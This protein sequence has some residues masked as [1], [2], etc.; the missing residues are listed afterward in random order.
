MQIP[1]PHPKKGLPRSDEA[2]AAVLASFIAFPDETA[3]LC[4]QRKIGSGHFQH[5]FYVKAFN[6]CMSLWERGKSV[7]FVNVATEYGTEE[8]ER[9]EGSVKWNELTIMPIGRLPEH[10][11]ILHD[12]FLAREVWKICRDVGEE[13]MDLAAKGEESLNALL[14]RAGAISAPT[15]RPPTMKELV[16]DKFRRMESNEVDKS[17]VQTGLEK[18][19]QFSPLRFGSMPLIAGERKA[20]K[21]MVAM[22]IAVNCAERKIRVMYF[23]LEMPAEELVDRIYAKIAGIPTEQHSKS[24]M[25]E[26]QLR[27]MEWAS[28]Q[29]ALLP[30]DIRDDVYDLTQIAATLR[31]HKAMFPDLGV[32]VVDYAQLVRVSLGKGANREQEVAHVSRTLRLL[33]MELKV[34]MLVLCQLNKEGE[35]RES[36]SL[37]QDCTA[38]WK[39]GSPDEKAPDERLFYIPFQRSGPSGIGFKVTYIGSLCRVLNYSGSDEPIEQAHRQSQPPKRAK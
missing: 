6:V 9:C 29:M 7:E 28:K 26:D 8:W 30:M 38:M 16:I 3:A 4:A 10:L 17:I 27:K 31:H 12:K 23:S 13:A 5:G 22:N 18:L 14:T 21:S 25:D 2:E 19:D 34:A 33:S 24:A 35:T 11:D 36:K 39:L 20:G 37:E 32:V 15:K 1:T